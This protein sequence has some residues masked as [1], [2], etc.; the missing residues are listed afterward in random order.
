MVVKNVGLNLHH[1]DQKYLNLTILTQHGRVKLRVSRVASGLSEYQ[2][3]VILSLLLFDSAHP[4]PVEGHTCEKTAF[5][6][7][8]KIDVFRH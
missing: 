3:R 1:R 4:E 7:P 6:I 8:P 2:F 5:V